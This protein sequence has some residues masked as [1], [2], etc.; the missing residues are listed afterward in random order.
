M[1]DTAKV[2]TPSLPAV[3][4]ASAGVTPTKRTVIP[5]TTRMTRMPSEPRGCDDG[6]RREL[7]D[8]GSDNEWRQPKNENELQR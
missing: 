6:D 8:S 1:A 3:R 5:V 4:A 7:C 2:R